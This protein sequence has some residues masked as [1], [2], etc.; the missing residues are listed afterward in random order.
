[1]IIHWEKNL[2]ICNA[3]MLLI[4]LYTRTLTRHLC[5][6]A[7]CSNYRLTKQQN[8]D[9]FNN[10]MVQV[11]NVKIM[12][13]I[14][15]CGQYSGAVV[16]TVTSQQKGPAHIFPVL[17]ILMKKE[18]SMQQSIT[19][20]PKSCTCNWLLDIWTVKKCLASVAIHHQNKAIS[21]NF[22]RREINILAHS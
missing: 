15:I 4:I 19:C 14:I 22:R 8:K 10:E 18:S 9:Q 2:I 21:N 16:S 5:R 12:I 6:N 17:L 3:L 13:I 11:C 1:M 20:L 7:H